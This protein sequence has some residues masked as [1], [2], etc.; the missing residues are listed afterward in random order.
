MTKQEIIAKVQS[1]LNNH[2]AKVVA[3]EKRTE[4]F[5]N[6]PLGWKKTIVIENEEE[7]EIDGVKYEI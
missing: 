7:V 6:S 2:E 4:I 3:T 5:T 1:I